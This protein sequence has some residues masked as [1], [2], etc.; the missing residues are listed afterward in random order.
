MKH[1]LASAL[2]ALIFCKRILEFIKD[3]E[4]EEDF[5]QD[6]KSFSYI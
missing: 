3:I 6:F 1:D 5:I 4:E 2:D